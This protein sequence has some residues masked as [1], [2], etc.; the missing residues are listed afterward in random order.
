MSLNQ[1][2]PQANARRAKPGWS[3][4]SCRSFRELVMSTAGPN[5]YAG[6]LR[7]RTNI[8]G[9]SQENQETIWESNCVPE[10]F[11]KLL[12]CLP[13]SSAWSC[14]FPVGKASRRMRLQPISLP[15]AVWNPP[16]RPSGY[17]LPSIRS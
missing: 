9:L 17:P 13:E 8:I 15:A 6:D 10:P 12:L 5:L 14:K 4:Q 7:H 16:L 11:N 1:K 2:L 3:A